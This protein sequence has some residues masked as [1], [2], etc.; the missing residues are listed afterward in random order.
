MIYEINNLRTNRVNDV[1]NQES[2]SLQILYP[3]SKNFSYNICI[4][5]RLRAF[6]GV[7]DVQ[8]VGGHFPSL[9]PFNR[10]AEHMSRYIVVINHR[11]IILGLRNRQLTMITTSL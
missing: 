1:L 11:Y 5:I 7:R 3:N 6:R 4:N 2:Y 8:Y 10:L 9:R